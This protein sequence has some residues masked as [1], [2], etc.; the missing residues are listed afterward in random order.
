MKYRPIVLFF[1]CWLGF[2]LMTLLCF[3]ASFALEEGTA[4]TDGILGFIVMLLDKLTPIIFVPESA[5][6]KLFGLDILSVNPFGMGFFLNGLV[7]SL[8]VY[9]IMYVIRIQERWI[10]K[11]R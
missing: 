1:A 8:F 10:A 3:G 11:K 4:R 5:S 9:L 7:W 6:D 2:S